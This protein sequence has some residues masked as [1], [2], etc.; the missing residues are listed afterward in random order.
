MRLLGAFAG[1]SPFFPGGKA[2]AAAASK[3]GVGNFLD[4]IL[5]CGL[6]RFTE[7]LISAPRPI[8]L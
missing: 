6:Y 8:L 2:C 3:A 4:D 7:G 5:R 1:E